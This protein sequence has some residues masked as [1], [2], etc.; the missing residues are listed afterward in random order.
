MS[1]LKTQPS[2]VRWLLELILQLAWLQDAPL[3]AVLE[4][5]RSGGTGRT[6][7]K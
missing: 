7:L 3:N 6:S 4:F 5:Q 2:V 1:S